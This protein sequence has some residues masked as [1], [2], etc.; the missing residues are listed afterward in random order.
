MTTLMDAPV[1]APETTRPEKTRFNIGRAGAWAFMILVIVVSLFPF[2]WMLRTALSSNN[3]LYAGGD[4]LLP[5]QFSWGG[6]A[7]VFGLQT[8]Q[9]AI[10][11]GGAGQPIQFWHYL[12]NSVI[13]STLV[14][15]G[16]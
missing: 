7:R 11:A 9:E 4:S 5:V 12:I 14:T 6:F 1:A 10:D 8:G 16:Q 13:V 2:Y 3:A 15:A